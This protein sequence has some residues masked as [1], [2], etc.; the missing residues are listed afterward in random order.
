MDHVLTVGEIYDKAIDLCLRNA[1]KIALTM[2]LFSL[3]GDTL[4]VLAD[5]SNNDVLLKPMH[6]H[7]HVTTA[8]NGWF[9]G[10]GIISSY[11]VFPVVE[12]GLYVLFDRA[13]R[14]EPIGVRAMLR[15]PIPRIANTAVASFLAAVYSVAPPGAIV[16]IFVLLLMFIKQPAIDVVLGLAAI[17]AAVWLLGF[18]ASGVAIGFARVALEN[19]RVLA[20]LRSGIAS[21]FAKAE[22]RRALGV[23]IPLAFILIAGNFGG[24]YLGIIAF[25][26][27][28]ADAANVVVQV[29][30]DIVAWSLTAAVATVYYRNLIPI[31]RSQI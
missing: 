17:V 19:G 23:G 31:G 13:L 18:L 20:S 8:V 29:I 26:L 30:G 5:P 21:V 1:G 28:G 12:A 25:G 24:Y 14:G 6:L 4:N 15:A 22:R 3:I 9:L 2:G 11:I 16:A 7:L 10:L 27:T